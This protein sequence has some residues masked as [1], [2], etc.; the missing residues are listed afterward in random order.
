M[1]LALVTTD[2][3]VDGAQLLGVLGLNLFFVTVAVTHQRCVGRSCSPMSRGS[4]ST[5]R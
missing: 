4:P 2:Y 3:R 5:W 1:T